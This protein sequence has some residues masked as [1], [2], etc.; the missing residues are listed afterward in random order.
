MEAIQFLCGNFR[1]TNFVYAI[2]SDLSDWYYFDED[3]SYLHVHVSLPPN[4]AN[5]ICRLDKVKPISVNLNG[6]QIVDYVNDGIFVFK[7][8]EL[9]TCKQTMFIQSDL[10]F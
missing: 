6:D 5:E 8:K 1:N 10:V 3:D 4:L 7:G 9:K 2:R